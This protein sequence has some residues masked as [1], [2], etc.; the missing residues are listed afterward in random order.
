MFVVECRHAEMTELRQ[1]CPAVGKWFR[2]CETV[3]GAFAAA[4]LRTATNVDRNRP[5]VEYRMRYL[6]EQPR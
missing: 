6:P 1:R 2:I 4:E 5:G 3:D